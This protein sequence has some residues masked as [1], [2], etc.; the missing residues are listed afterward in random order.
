[1]QW[2][3]VYGAYGVTFMMITSFIFSFVR[4]HRRIRRRLSQ[5]H[6]Q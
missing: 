4:Q 5:L 2:D 1:M 6:D 3:Y